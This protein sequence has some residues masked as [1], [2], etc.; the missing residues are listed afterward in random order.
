[1]AGFSTIEADITYGLGF[2]SSFGPQVDVFG[3]YANGSGNAGGATASGIASSV[4]NSLIG[5][6]GVSASFGQLFTNAR[7]VRAT[8]RETSKVME[9]PLETGT[10]IADHHIINPVEMDIQL[11]VTNSTSGLVNSVLNGAIVQNYAS[12]FNQIRQAFVNA[13]LLTVKTRVGTYSNMIIADMPHEEDPDMFDVITIGLHLKQ[14]LFVAPG[15]NT[16]SQAFQ[17]LD[18]LNSNTI[19]GGLQQAT[20]LGS[21]LVAQAGAVSSYAAVLQKGLF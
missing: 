14:V 9:H 18:P 15:T 19:T 5:Q 6:S 17:P 20:A 1:M 2:L 13:T 7:P 3:I 4:L 8:I 11:I 21:N 16:I 12:T 10:S